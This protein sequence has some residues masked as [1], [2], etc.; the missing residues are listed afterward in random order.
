M[1]DRDSEE[2]REMADVDR[3]ARRYGKF[4]LVVAV[5]KRA[6]DLRERSS[7]SLAPSTGSFIS[8]A[9]SEI[10]EGKVKVVRRQEE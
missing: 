6:R 5:A 2:R 8:K 4:T 10:S 3:M 1:P 7:R 9:L